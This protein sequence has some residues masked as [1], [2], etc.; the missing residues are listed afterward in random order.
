[1]C[2]LPCLESVAPPV[3]VAVVDGHARAKPARRKKPLLPVEGESLVGRTAKCAPG[4]RLS[5][6]ARGFWTRQQDTYFEVWVNHQKVTV[7][8]RSEASSQLHSHKLQKKRQYAEWVNV[9]DR[10]E[11]SSQLHS[12]K[13]QKKRQYAEWVN[14]VDRSEASSQLHSHELQKKRQHAEWVNVVDRGIF[15]P[16]FFH[17]WY[18]WS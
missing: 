15:T 17:L 6:R 10:S 8:S 4:A 12:H 2:L 14:V 9:V 13:L 1:M 16:W 18:D 11:A 7:L 5:I 3:V